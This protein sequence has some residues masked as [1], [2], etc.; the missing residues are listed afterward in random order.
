MNIDYSSE[1]GANALAKMISEYWVARGYP[2]VAVFVDQL[3]GVDR[4]PVHI[5]CSNIAPRG[6]PPK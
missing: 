6:Y 4:C 5:I 1:T 2:K 3:V